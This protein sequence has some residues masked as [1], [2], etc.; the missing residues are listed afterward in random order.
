M[1]AFLQSSIGKA[2]HGKIISVK[3]I[4]A[5]VEKGG[6][7]DNDDQMEYFFQVDKA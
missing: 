2:R 7:K 4:I 3:I 6:R 5:R 1:F